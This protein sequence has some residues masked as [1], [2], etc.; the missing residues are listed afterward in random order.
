MAGNTGKQ[1]SKNKPSTGTPADKR[2]A[3]RG[4]K[5]GPKPKAALDAPFRIQARSWLPGA[6]WSLS[7]ASDAYTTDTEPVMDWGV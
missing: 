3:G 6:P 2:K 1:P 4:A 7:G 5:P